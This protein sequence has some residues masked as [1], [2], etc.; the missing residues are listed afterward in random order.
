MGLAVEVVMF[1]YLQAEVLQTVL[2]KITSHTLTYSLQRNALHT[3]AQPP[4]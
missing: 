1:I 3:H 2:R 4:T